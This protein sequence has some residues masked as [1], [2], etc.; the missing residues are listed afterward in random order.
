MEFLDINLTKDSSLLLHAI[1][2]LSTDRFLKKIRIY[3]GFK[4]TNKQ[5]REIRKLESIHE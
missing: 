2:S 3:S 4:N 1:H 5:I